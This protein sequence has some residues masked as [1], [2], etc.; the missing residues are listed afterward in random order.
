[1]YPFE[2]K[3]KILDRIRNVGQI[4]ISED[5]QLF[6]VSTSTLHRD[7]EDLARQGLIKKVMGGAV[8]VRG[9]QFESHFDQRMK[10]RVAEKMAIAKTA[11]KQV[12]DDTSIYLDHSSTTAYLARE[13]KGHSYKSLVVLTNSL[14]I[15]HELGGIQGIQ[16]ISTGGVVEGEFKALSGRRVIES[17]QGINLHNVFISVGAISVEH[18]LM[19]QIPF[20]QDLVPELITHGQQINVMVDSSK[21]FKIGTFHISSLK[22]SFIIYTDKDLP[23]DIRYEIE[24]KGLTVVI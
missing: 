13:L 1:M 2:R 12:L 19:T 8:L 21:F 14:Q 7:L 18:G 10:T 15:Q 16:V 20:I 17:L 5:A 3:E 11:A 4:N 6:H 9:N 24:E 23:D 22:P